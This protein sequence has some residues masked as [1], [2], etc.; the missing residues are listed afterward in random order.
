M[1]K[2]LFEIIKARYIDGYRLLFTFNEGVRIIADLSN[3]LNSFI[4]TPLKDVIS[5][6]INT[7]EW[8]IRFVFVTKYKCK[9]YATAKV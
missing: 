4:H 5:I 8:N 2:M 9:I 3:F 6:I 1:L 7:V